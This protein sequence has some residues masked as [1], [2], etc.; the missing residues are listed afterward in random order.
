MGSG[1]GESTTEQDDV[2]LNKKG[3]VFFLVL[4][5]TIEV[6]SSIYRTKAD[7]GAEANWLKK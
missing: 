1:E 5:K 2:S 7:A 6:K 4:K 3:S